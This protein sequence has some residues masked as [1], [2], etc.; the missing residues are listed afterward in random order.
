MIKQIHFFTITA[1]S[2]AMSACSVIP[3]KA[4]T[5]IAVPNVPLDKN[6]EVLD[7]ETISVP[8][9]PSLAGLRWQDFYADPKLKQLIQMGLEHNKDLEQAIL[10]IQSA[11]AKYQITSAG[12]LPTVS[13]S[14]GVTRSA[15]GRDQNP[16]T[17]YN[18]GLA[19]SSY[20]LDFW[21]KVANSKEAALHDFLATNAAK[22]AAQISLIS[23]IAQTYVNLSYALAQRHLAKETLKTREHSLMI[24]K[25]RFSAGIDSRSPSLQ[26]EA[27]LES[28][29]ISIYE[30]DT[31]ILQLKNALQLLIGKPIPKELMP[32]M[33]VANIT[34][35]TIFQTGLP[36]E[37]LY[38]RPDIVQAEHALRAAGAN[39]DVARAAY[40]PSISLSS[41][42]GYS[43]SHLRDLFNSSAFGWSFGPSISLPIF[44]AGSRRANYEV[45]EVA[46][47]SAL[48]AYEKSIQTAFKE[49]NDVLATRATLGQRL[50]SQYR[51]QKNYQQTYD[52]A[53]ARFRSGLDDYLNVLDAERS[54]FANQ[55]GILSL[56]Q[57]KI[58]SQIELYQR[59]GGGAS[60]TAEQIAEFHQ[61]REAMKTANLA[62][63][64]DIANQK[65]Q[66]EDEKLQLTQTKPDNIRVLEP[67]NVAGVSNPEVQSVQS[68]ANQSQNAMSQNATQADV[69]TDVSMPPNKSE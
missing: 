7:Q 23:N 5:P 69:Q 14:A 18:V 29:K 47:K 62:T 33:A 8:Q 51:L 64:A 9:R 3:P 4:Q 41:N 61:Q 2:L 32:E 26:A 34:T 38:Y 19:M 24:T 15:G 11:K 42:I 49:V 36:S 55:Q 63:L 17:A 40:F 68:E 48:A 45:A 39:I 1:L 22:D 56:E 12:G 37:L 44:D 13:A 10:A 35:Q 28:A 60:L 31:N 65:T 16:S 43:S 21:G 54:L 6:F 57:Q 50:D 20:E 58:I 66:I 30:A 52:I 25:K 59:L 67:K 27:S 46:Q 53:Y